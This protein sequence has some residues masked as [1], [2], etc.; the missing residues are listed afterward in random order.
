[1]FN[2]TKTKTAR[3]YGVDFLVILPVVFPHVNGL[4]FAKVL[5]LG[6]VDPATSHTGVL[7]ANHSAIEAH[8]HPYVK[9]EVITRLDIIF[10]V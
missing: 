5:A 8:H 9:L 7:L 6:G 2:G 3:V 4:L 1:M 10:I